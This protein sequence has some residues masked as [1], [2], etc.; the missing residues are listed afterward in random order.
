[1]TDPISFD[2][3]LGWVDT[4]DPDN[5]PED[6]R[7]IGADDLLRYENF[8]VAATTAINELIPDVEAASNPP[9]SIIVDKPATFP[10]SVHTHTGAD[11]ALATTALPGAMSAADKTK[12]DNATP[13]VTVNQLAQ[14]DAEGRMQVMTPADDYDVA[15]KLYVDTNIGAVGADTGWLTVPLN[16]TFVHSTAFGSNGLKI[17]VKNGIVFLNGRIENPDPWVQGEVIASNLTAID[18]AITAPTNRAVGVNMTVNI[19]AYAIT[20]AAGGP[21]SLLISATWPTG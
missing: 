16:G 5:L 21:G 1:M 6:V 9:W 2:P 13:N 15:T 11:L 12:L 14:R 10:P 20:M 7:I 17:R 4:T 8:G 18:A 3:F 19:E